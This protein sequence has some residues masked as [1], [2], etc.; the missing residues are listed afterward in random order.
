VLLVD[1]VL[2]VGDE[3]F[4]RRP[5]MRAVQAPGQDLVAGHDRWSAMVRPGVLLDRDA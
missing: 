5:E 4:V 1:E 3:S 2:A